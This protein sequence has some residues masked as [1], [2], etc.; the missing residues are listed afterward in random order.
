MPSAR[1]LTF[2]ALL[3]SLLLAC[4]PAS[5]A[6]DDENEEKSE[7][8]DDSNP[9]KKSEEKW[10]VSD[11]GGPYRSL[12]FET[13]EGTWMCV[14]VHPDGHTLVFDLLGDIYTIP[15]DG[16]E[17]KRILG[18]LP[19]ELQPR[20]SPDGKSVLFTSD[21]G[22]ADNI[23]IADADGS[24]PRQLT[25]EKFRL[26]N[27][28]A[29]HPNGEYFV[30]RKHFTS[31]RSLGAGE[32]WM[33]H[34]SNPGSGVQL[35]KRRTDQKDAGEPEFSPDGRYLYWSEDMTPGRI[36]EYN[37]DPNG[38]I[39]VLRRL[40][41]QTGEIRNLIQQAGGA[42]RPQISPDGKVLAFVRRR[43]NQSVLALYDLESGE[44]RD[45]WD[46]L[47]RD[48]QE[49]WAIFGVYPGF[50]WT[51]DGGSIVLSAKGGLYRINV[52][53]GSVFK[54]RFRVK[55]EH[56]L[57]ETRREQLSAGDP[58]FP[59]KVIRWPQV[60]G[61]SEVV[62]QALGH[63]FIRNVENGS[64]PRRLT[65]LKNGFEFAPRLTRDGRNILYV[66]WDDVE[67]GQIRMTGLDD[68]AS[69]VLVQRPGHYTSCDL[70]SDG[71]TLVYRRG[72]QD[73]Y[74]GQLYSEDP[75]IYALELGAPESEARLLTREGSDPRFSADGTRI[76][77]QSR[78]GSKAALISVNLL[79][80]D[81][82]VHAVSERAVDFVLSPDERYLAFEELWQ[83]YVTPFPASAATISVGPKMKNLPVKRLS[84]VAGTYLSW[85]PDGKEIRW[86][87]GPELFSSPIADLFAPKLSKK[88][89]GD[90]GAD[91]KDDSAEKNSS[92]PKRGVDAKNWNLGWMQP[93]DIPAT[94]VYFVGARILPMDDLS[95]I[96][97]GVVH[98]S[99]NRIQAVGSRDEIP[100]P[101][102]SK[103][104]DV[105]GKT[106]LP[107]YVDT[108][109]HTGSSN[110]SINSQQNW[111]FL[112]NLAFGVTATHD[113]SNNTQM[114]HAQAELMKVGRLLAPR[115][116]STGTILYGAEG[117]FKAVID[118]Y[119]DALEAVR[120]TKAWGAF[121][122]KSYNQPRRDQRQMV[123][124]AARE[125][126][127]L[128]MPEGGSTFHHNITMLFDG[129][130]TLE[131]AIPLTPLYEPELRL[132]AECGTT[133]T[134]TLVVG[135]GGLWGENYWYQ[136]S[137]V[138]TNSRLR[139]FVPSSVVVPRSRRRVMVPH[140]EFHHI[141]LAK[142]CAEVVSRGGNV[143][144]GA[145]GQMQGI[146]VHW[147][148]WMFQ[149]G[150]MTNHEALRAGTYMGAKAIGMDES[151]GSI[152]AGLL[153]DL[154]VVDGDPIA[155]LRDSEKV[156]YTMINGRL[157]DAKTM[158]QIAPTRKPLPQGPK[159][160]TLP[161]AVANVGS[162]GCQSH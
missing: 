151:F 129:H 85:S 114:I 57:V 87:L 23:W 33:Y 77:L 12:E 111:A 154:I 128:V 34:V 3:A 119:E 38:T 31:T 42:V 2:L 157:F 71:S 135:Y 159:L 152:R 15:I 54:I 148:M 153:A 14:D 145:H 156:L 122:V 65:R 36:F 99:G 46:G 48:Q 64:K 24:N 142:I 147:E 141:E 130:T 127:I 50:D 137:E 80:S 26:L 95:T 45:L 37:K 113:P 117:N 43:D 139:R 60:V 120:R 93:T 1:A 18:G 108:H 103:V 68:S 74:R 19:Y 84:E 149:Q 92:G 40:D 4:P 17:A 39:Y 51:P 115:I 44:V 162:C 123:I 96:E 144:V 126:G 25:Q 13:E 56:Q 155:D 100:I 121:S 52:M 8:K 150:G 35:T 143:T 30:A 82:R 109:A 102:K 49:T 28:P 41:M 73:G 89:E 7:K 116:Y 83:T 6:R 133:Y 59:V 21:R 32:M 160:E 69:E 63:L 146:G 58:H 94:N 75:G 136:K 98:V 125:E 11:P 67:G 78:E 131:H 16:G 106:L 22:G 107:G 70:S 97:D 53:T 62:F 55:V 5:H 47:S 104:L 76:Y 27:N 105:S 90:G 86:S 110:S 88:A 124:K 79:G 158:S 81:R 61:P 9:E 140:E 118:N 91:G 29:W 20:F 10:E 161:P 132:L 66:T 138:W 112:A 134:P 101:P 72:P